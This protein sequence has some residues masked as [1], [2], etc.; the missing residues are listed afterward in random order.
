MPRIRV[1]I[2]LLMAVIPVVALYTAGIR[3]LMEEITGGVAQAWAKFW[4]VFGLALM[5]IVLLSLLDDFLKRRPKKRVPAP[6]WQQI[7]ASKMIYVEP[8]GLEVGQR[9]RLP[10]GTLLRVREYPSYRLQ[11]ILDYEPPCQRQE[12]GKNLSELVEVR[13]DRS[14]WRYSGERSEAHVVYEETPTGWTLDDL[15]RIG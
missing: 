8:L 12:R 5:T 13:T 3:F 9:F 2:W 4:V 11:A 15:E 7:H 1:P 14:I 6:A 10:D